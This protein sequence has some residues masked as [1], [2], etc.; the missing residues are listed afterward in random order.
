MSQSQFT[1]VSH[2]LCPFVQRVAILL[3]EKGVPF[4]RIDV[5][6]KDRPDWFVAMSPTG[7]VPLL[8]V[9]DDNEGVT[10][11]FES[12]AI[13]EYL[14]EV[15]PEPA[16]HPETALMRAQHRAWI[17]FATAMLADAWGYLNAADQQTALGKSAT[18][19]GKLE[20][21]DGEKS[22]GPFFAGGKFGMVDIAVAPVFRY[23]DILGFEPDHQLF[24]GL[25]RVAE[26]R[27]ALASRASIQ[28]A[29]AED[30]ESRFR[31]HLREGQAVLVSAQ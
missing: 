18:L 27:C 16:L 11:L 26:W 24:I 31:K 17:E 14:E 10:V 8:T 30:Y 12:V 5:D 7:K 22:D 25:N 2:G 15:Y 23:F 9:P 20:R 28:A 19:R 1:L 13:C 21:L 3:L 29:V 4:Q 6:L